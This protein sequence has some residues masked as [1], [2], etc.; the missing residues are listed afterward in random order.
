ML[1][2]LGTNVSHNQ[3]RSQP[4]LPW[5]TVS[6]QAWPVEEILFPFH[7]AALGRTESNSLLKLCLQRPVVQ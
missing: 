7:A 5:E 6:F 4:H 3:T 2:A 1:E